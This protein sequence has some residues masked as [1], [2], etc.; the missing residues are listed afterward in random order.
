ME[1]V[2]KNIINTAAILG[3]E[4]FQPSGYLYTPVSG[5]SRMTQHSHLTAIH[6]VVIL[7][8]HLSWGHR[9]M[10]VSVLGLESRLYHQSFSINSTTGLSR[11]ITPTWILTTCSSTMSS[12]SLLRL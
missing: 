3:T 10:Y 1:C 11:F 6:A 12:I 2:C 7:R 5:P 4:P 9:R 8:R